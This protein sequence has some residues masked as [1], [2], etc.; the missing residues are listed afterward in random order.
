MKGGCGFRIEN[1]EKPT[2]LDEM[3]LINEEEKKLLLLDLLSRLQKYFGEHDIRWFMCAGSLLGAVRHKG[4][5]PWD[6]D[7]DISIPRTDFIRLIHLLENDFEHL[8]RN[9]MVLLHF[10]EHKKGYHKRFK[11]ADTRTEMVEY[12]EKRPAVFVDVFPLDFYDAVNVEDSRKLRRKVLNIDNLLVLCHSGYTTNSGIKGLVYKMLLTIFKLAGTQKAERTLEKKLL[13]IT[14]NHKRVAGVT[15]GS[16]GDHE[17]S[18]QE[19]YSE[20]VHLPF[21]SLTVPCPI[22][23]N[24]VLTNMYGDYMIPP[25]AD[26]IHNHSY[27]KMYW[28]DEY[29]QQ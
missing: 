22:G 1:D 6:D 21:E 12:G 26:Q 20:I 24:E 27:Y 14:T 25:P 23:Y 3:R 16:Y 15:E 17:F 9:N 7:I 29:E 5:I 18:K 10:D 2:L 19:C 4:F 28:K 11:I 8:E 13:K